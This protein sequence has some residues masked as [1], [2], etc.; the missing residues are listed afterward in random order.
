MLSTLG[1]M[2]TVGIVLL[3]SLGTHL[4]SK[5]LRARRAKQ[6]SQRASPAT[7]TERAPTEWE[8]RLAEL[9]A[10]VV[11]L[12]SSFEKV[13]KGVTRLN[14]R[15]G[16]RELRSDPDASNHP[17]PVTAS[18]AE[19]YRYYGIAGRTPRDIA[20]HQLNLESDSHDRRPN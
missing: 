2:L 7:S 19:K 14:S 9:R 1:V 11:S 3:Y 20:Q 6:R 18:K 17:P 15:A 16:M 13:A 4:V 12:S 8:S 10:D 5:L